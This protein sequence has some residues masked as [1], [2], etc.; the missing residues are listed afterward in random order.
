MWTHWV[1]PLSPEQMTELSILFLK[2]SP[3]SLWRK[4]IFICDHILSL[5]T[6]HDQRWGFVMILVCFWVFF[7]FT[8]VFLFLVCLVSWVSLQFP[9]VPS[10]SSFIPIS[11]VNSFVSFCPLTQGQ[12]LAVI[13]SFSCFRFPP[14]FFCRV[15]FFLKFLLFLQHCCD[16]D[17]SL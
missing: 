15:L 17:F 10:V 3:C 2:L 9:S 7:W 4:L 12:I 16:F 5:T 1:T 8:F 13:S 6:A 14:E 11:S